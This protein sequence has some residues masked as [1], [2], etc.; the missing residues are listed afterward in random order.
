MEVH[1][2]RCQSCGS[3]DQHNLLVRQRGHAQTVLVRC[4]QCGEL[5]ARY[6]LQSY[7]HHGKGVESYLRSLGSEACDSGRNQ[8]KQFQQIQYDATGQYEE[9]LKALQEEGKEP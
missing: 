8:L 6:R 5:V 7:Y 3:L 4:A 1:R 2:Q 9:A